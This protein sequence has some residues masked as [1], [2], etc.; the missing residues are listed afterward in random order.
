MTHKVAITFE[1]LA[2]SRECTCRSVLALQS[3]DVFNED[4]SWRQLFDNRKQSE[5]KTPTLVLGL[6]LAIGT[7]GLARSAC[8][9]EEWSLVVTADSGFDRTRFH[10]S[11]VLF[12][13]LCPWKIKSIGFACCRFKIEP[14]LYVHPSIPKPRARSTTAAEEVGHSNPRDCFTHLR[15]R[16]IVQLALHDVCDRENRDDPTFWHLRSAFG[17][18]LHDIK[19]LCLLQGDLVSSLIDVY[20]SSSRAAVSVTDFSKSSSPRTACAKR[21]A[22]RAG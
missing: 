4:E 22:V 16:Q 17:T 21:Q 14:E 18:A 10:G 19:N 8:A 11:Y 5:Q 12:E 20:V 6:S 9:Y 13:K 1:T 7:V 15:V 3:W 2:E